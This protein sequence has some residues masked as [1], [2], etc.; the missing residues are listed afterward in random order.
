M[1]STLDQSLSPESFLL[2]QLLDHLIFF[3]FFFFL[4]L[5]HA[6]MGMLLYKILTP[7]H[8]LLPDEDDR[9]KSWGEVELR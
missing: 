1:S 5:D 3:L 7:G 9:S 6:L 8:F 4:L 2:T